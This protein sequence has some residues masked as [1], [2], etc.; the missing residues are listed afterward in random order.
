VDLV[1]IYDGK[2]GFKFSNDRLKA[3]KGRI[4]N[5]PRQTSIQI[6]WIRLFEIGAKELL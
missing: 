3:C 2:A 6:A 1:L 4:L 5:T